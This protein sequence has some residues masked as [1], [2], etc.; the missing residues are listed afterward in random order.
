MYSYVVTGLWL[1]D[2]ASLAAVV[3]I[4]TPIGANCF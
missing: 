3:M 4:S 2:W 1:V